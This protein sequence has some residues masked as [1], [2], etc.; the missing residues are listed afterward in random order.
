MLDLLFTNTRSLVKSSYSVQGISDH[1]RLVNDLDIHPNCVTKKPRKSYMYSK[2]DCDS[3]NS[4]TE[5][6]SKT[7]LQIINLGKNVKELW[8]MFKTKTFEI[9]EKFIPTKNLKGRRSVS[10]FS[11]KL[12]RK[13]RRQAR[14]YK[15]E[16]N[17]QW[18]EFKS[19]QRQCKRALETGQYWYF[20]AQ[21]IRD[22][23]L[24]K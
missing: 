1:Q 15:H 21:N 2:A 17:K 14:L 8:T 11:Y 16:K 9:T 19:F 18:T 10:L 13:T 6:F 24:C 3:I 23:I 12:Q 22:L 7:L 4:E 20:T 5:N